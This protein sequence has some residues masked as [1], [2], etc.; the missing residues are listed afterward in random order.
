MIRILLDQNFDHRI[1]DGLLRRIPELDVDST[2]RLGVKKFAD[3]SILT[4]AAE[5][6]RVVFTH[7]K[8]IFPGFARKKIEAGEKMCGLIVVS[9]RIPIGEAIYELELLILCT[10]DDEWENSVVRVPI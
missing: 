6:G 9:D 1:S 4:L 5:L 3:D 7:D 8:R 10:A 2:E